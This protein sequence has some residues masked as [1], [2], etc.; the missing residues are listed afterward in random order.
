M[1]R[2]GG[3]VRRTCSSKVDFDRPSV[4]FLAIHLLRRIFGRFG[5]RKFHVTEPS[6]LARISVHH[7]RGPFDFAVVCKRRLEPFVVYAP[8]ELSNEESLLLHTLV[9][10]EFFRRRLH[11]VFCFSL[12]RGY[13]L[14]FTIGLNNRSDVDSRVAAGLGFS[15][16]SPI[17]TSLFS[18]LEPESESESESDESPDSAF[19]TGATP[20]LPLTAFAADAGF[21]SSSGSDSEL[22]LEPSSELSSESSLDAGGL[23]GLAFSVASESPSEDEDEDEEDEDEEEESTFFLPFPTGAALTCA[24]LGFSSFSGPLSESESESLDSS[25]AGIGAAF[26]DAVLASY[27]CVRSGMCKKY[28]RVAKNS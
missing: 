2:A 16:A 21:A 1:L 20:G 5:S 13:N 23:V 4:D 18:S 3:G 24:A 11:L 9:R 25:L 10:F 7:Y 8:A 6:R 28:T 12:L 14:E 22:S 19:F 17:S 15:V 26:F 27:E